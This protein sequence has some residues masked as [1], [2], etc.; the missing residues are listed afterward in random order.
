[1]AEKIVGMVLAGGKGERLYPLTQDRAKP[2][3]PF[4][5]KYRIIDFTL[6]NCLNSGIRRLNLLTQYKS[7]SL[8]RHI[9]V[10]WN[11]FNPQLDEY[12]NL[13]PAQQRVGEGW[14]LGTADAIYQNIYVL[15][16]D[17]P[18]LVLILSGDHIYKMNY[19]DMISYHRERQADLTVA[20][21]E[22]NKNL[23]RQLGVLQVDDDFRIV[24]FE[25]KPETPKTIPGDADLILANMGVYVFNTEVLVRRVI[26]DAK[27]PDSDHDFGKNV[28]PAMVSQDRVF[29]YSFRDENKKTAKY[30]RDIGTLD[31]YYDASMD[32]V[33]IDPLFNIYDEDWPIRTYHPPTPPAKTVFFEEHEGGRIGGV[34]NSIISGDCIISGGKVIR[35]VLSPKVR[36]HSYS[37]V[38]DSILMEGVDVGRYARVNRAIV[39]K[40][41]RI[42]QGY[43]IGFNLSEDAKKFTV[44]ESGIVV[45]SKGTILG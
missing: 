25:E 28:I 19:M 31:A 36:I 14:Y 26:E 37:E 38:R 43:A 10:G 32:L 35:S 3:V 20:V 13:I 8:N 15:Q 24:G 4:G 23:S 2:A 11:I 30:W 34:Y 22:M 18:D 45:I 27:H 9:M 17:R 5:G 6:S 21:I 39:D 1:M 40:G 29:A 16:M 42:P 12:I 33:A 7:L 44:T 41:V